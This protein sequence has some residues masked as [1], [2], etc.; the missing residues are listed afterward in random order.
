MNLAL[1]NNPTSPSPTKERL[2]ALAALE[3]VRQ[4]SPV[5]TRVSDLLISGG[6]IVVMGALGR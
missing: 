5:L 3:D 1:C 4:L 6:R 2:V